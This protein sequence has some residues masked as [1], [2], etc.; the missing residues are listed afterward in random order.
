M[1]GIIKQFA[2]DISSI[3]EEAT[4]TLIH[5]LLISGF[6]L[7]ESLRNIESLFLEQIGDKYDLNSPALTLV[8]DNV[9]QE[10]FTT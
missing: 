8:K 10:Y 5:I 6:G 4:N 2:V 7:T 1:N 9:L 3:A